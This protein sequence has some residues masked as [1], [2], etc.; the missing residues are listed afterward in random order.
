MLIRFHLLAVAL[1]GVAA[2]ASADEPV[3][4]PAPPDLFARENLVAWCIVPYDA[5]RRGPEERAAMLEKLGVHRLAYDYRAEHVPTFDAEMDA[6]ARHHIELVAWWYP[7][8]MNDEARLILQVLERHQLHPQ[9]WVTGGGLATKSPEEQQARIEAE[10]KRIRPIAEAAAKIGS[11]VSLY[12]HGGWFGEPENELAVLELLQKQGVKNIGI[13]YNFHHGHGDLKRF[14]ELFAKMQPHLLALNLNGMTVDGDKKGEMILP[15]GQG[16]LDLDLLK[17]VRASGWF[18]PV[19]I[20]NHTDEDAE[21]RLRD[22]LEG[23]DWLVTQLD[24][25]PSGPKPVPSTWH[26]PQTVSTPAAARK[27]DAAAESLE[28]QVIP[29]AAANELTPA[30]GWP[31]SADLRGWSRSLGGPTSNRFSTL[32]EINRQNVK[33]LQVAWTY[34]SGDGS[35]NIQCNPIVVDGVMFAPTAGRHIVALDAATGRELWRFDPKSNGPRLEDVPARRGLLYWPGDADATARIIFAAGSSVYAIDPKT[36]Q[37][38][39]GFG[40]EGRTDLPTGGTVAGAI[41][42]HV[43]IVPGFNGDV[44]GYDT[45]N[46]SLLWRFH[47]IAEPGEVGAET[48]E[49]R[50][51]GANC[52]GGMAL[53]ESRGIAYVSTG[54]PKP[55]FNGTRHGGG[56]LFANCVLALDAAT[57]RRLWH[58]QEIRHDIWDLDIPA[59]PNLV[60]VMREGRRVDAVAQV[61]KLGNTLLLD[62][63]T[64]QPLFPYRLRRAPASKLTGEYTA[65]YQ[66]DPVL[67]E[68]FVKHR[69]T[70]SRDDITDR[71]PEAKASVEMLLSRANLGW[72]AP[73]EDSKPTAFYGLHGGAEWTGAA[74][75]SGSGRL[76]VTANELPWM[77]TVF[78][79]DD[80]PPAKPPTVGEQV[81]QQFCAACHGPDRAGIGMAPPLRGL[82]HRM[83][84]D[85]VLVLWKT[86]RNSMPPQLQLDDL[87]RK[88]LLDFL[89]V[90]DRPSL[91]DDPKSQP[92]YSFAGYQKVLDYEQ[93]PG[94]KPPWGT[95][96]CLDLNTGKL[97]WSVPLGEYAALTK[98]GIPKTGTENFGGAMVTAGGL[99]F[100][101]G[102]RDNKI[103]AFDSENGTELWSADLP[104]HGTAPPATYEV[105]GRQYVVIAATG[106]GKL[107]GPTGDAWVAF[108][109]PEKPKAP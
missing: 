89:F 75:D 30:N 50:E 104:L 39:A 26:D 90:R 78:R 33:D 56:N 53:D 97:A 61:T 16:D 101:S 37:P 88:Q 87:Q 34:H 103:R 66:P 32:T 5:A 4:P 25:R 93:Y 109:L 22:N 49:G 106:G 21:G 38:V 99:V 72:F 20:L 96:N 47:T 107:G 100:C 81:Y 18:G 27:K 86:G 7:S 29:A 46:G 41:W 91:P 13:V 94:C 10:A 82:R 69:F 31:S 19:G 95:L 63:V 44:F 35:A 60:T 98:A 65:A 3:H 76:Y 68:P 59:P 85:Q 58:F 62:R 8:V 28:F 83:T 51:L 42:K 77:I 102:T 74:F 48:W 14:A 12:N 64:G 67:P 73:F 17:T 40:H 6:L 11:S 84:D 79:D 105:G 1:I 36:G 2:L 43:L 92:R 70:F 57:G 108:A 15:L 23:L 55:N 9:L 71:T 52:W 45:V 80:A 54:S 24:G